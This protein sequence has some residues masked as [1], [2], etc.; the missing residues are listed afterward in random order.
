MLGYCQAA[1]TRVQWEAL[2][3]TRVAAS[4]PPLPYEVTLIQRRDINAYATPGGKVYVT[5]GL[6]SLLGNDPG[7][8]AGVLGHEI[9]HTL[10]RHHYRA[11][12]R[13][14]Q[15]QRLAAYYRA[16]AA[17]GDESATWALLAHN[18]AGGL[19][20][21]KLSRDDE[22]EAD[23]LGLMMMAEAG[24]HP[25]FA[26]TFQRRMRNTVGDHSKLR[27]FF[28][29][30]PRWVTRQQRTMKVYKKARTFFESR[31]T[32]PS[33]SPG[34]T[35]PPVATLGKVAVRRDKVTKAVNIDIP[36]SIRNAKDAPIV[37]A[38]RFTRKKKPVMA[39]LPEYQLSD[40]SL[41]AFHSLTPESWDV[42]T[43]VS[44]RV[45]TAALGTKHRK[46]KGTVAIVAGD[47]LLDQSKPF[48][49]SFPKP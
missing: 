19:V 48:K 20:N 30:H 10:G 40:G 16:L 33:Q 47:E 39:A 4:G 17:A 14:L 9:G 13:A 18:I 2:L 42:S 11:Y 23:R 12:L 28:S 44:V 7:M 43:T 8:W 41:A 32:D 15:N 27:A 31:W 5:S 1:S 35:P 26:T 3:Q 29:D 25:D 46:L 21:L 22:H 37:V 38:V 36:L 34:G 49:V 24:F 45:P 6:I